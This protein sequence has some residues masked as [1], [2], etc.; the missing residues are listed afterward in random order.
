MLEWVIISSSRDL[1]NRGIDLMSPGGGF[2]TTS[3]TGKPAYEV[4]TPNIHALV[5]EKGP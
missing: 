2:F 1:P 4:H 5:G 3:A